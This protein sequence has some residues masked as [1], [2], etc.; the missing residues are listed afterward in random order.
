MRSP[1]FFRG[2]DLLYY[3]EHYYPNDATTAHEFIHEALQNAESTHNVKTRIIIVPNGSYRICGK[4]M[5]SA[6]AQLCP[7]AIK[8]IFIFGRTSHFLPY[9][10]ALSSMDYLDSP[11]G[12]LPVDKK[13][14]FNVE[15]TVLT[16]LP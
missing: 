16:V 11:L 15:L 12:R 3:R 4:I 6:Y 7:E 1:V 8:R 10:G 9:M 5:G 2:R 13:S 14:E